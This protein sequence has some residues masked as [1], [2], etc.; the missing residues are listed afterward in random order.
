[1]LK[2][3]FFLFLFCC[4]FIANAAEKPGIIDNWDL[5]TLKHPISEK[6]NIITISFAKAGKIMFNCFKSIPCQSGSLVKLKLTVKGTGKL[7]MGCHGYN[8]KNMWITSVTGKALTLNPAKMETIEFNMS[9]PVSKK[10]VVKAIRPYIEFVGSK[11]LVFTNFNY[12]I[13]EPEQPKNEQATGGKFPPYF[14]RLNYK[15]GDFPVRVL[16]S[17]NCVSL[18]FVEKPFVENAM[19]ITKLKVFFMENKSSKIIKEQTFNFTNG[20]IKDSKIALPKNLKGEYKIVGEYLDKNHKVLCKGNGFT[21]VKFLDL[22]SGWYVVA[23]RKVNEHLKNIVKPYMVGQKVFFFG[24]Y[25]FQKFNVTLSAASLPGFQHPIAKNQQVKVLGRTYH[26]AKNGLPSQIDVMQNEPTVG[27]KWEKLLAKPI[28]LQLDGKTISSNQLDQVKNTSTTQVEVKN[29]LN[30]IFDISSTIEQDGVIKLNIK[31]K[32]NLKISAGN[33]RI[34]IPL[35]NSQATLYHDLTDLTYRRLNKKIKDVTKAGFGGHAGFVPTKKI[36]GNIV[37]QS[38]YC[39]RTHPGSFNAMVWL[40]NE[41]R[42]FCCFSDSDKD[43]LVDNNKSCFT[44]ERKDS[45]VILNIN[46]VNRKKALLPKEAS[47]T[48][49]LLATPAKQMSPTARGTIFPRWATLDKKFYKQLTNVKKIQMVGAGDPRFT[50]G[51]C[52]ILPQDSNRTKKMYESVKDD[53]NST[54]MEYYCSDYMS[55]AM[56]E[57]GM[58]FGEWSGQITGT[59]FRAP[60]NW[61]KPYKGFDFTH[62]S[63]IACRRI[64]PSYLQ[65]RL[66]CID[67][68]FKSSP[69]LSFYEDNIHLRDFFDPAMGYGYRAKDKSPRVEFDIW[70]LRNYYRKIAEIYRKHGVENQAG[71]HA[72]AAMIIPALTYC[73]YFIDGEQPGRY[74]TGPNKDYVD[75]WKDV[76]Y[77]RGHILGRQFGIR[78]IFLS[79]IV[80]KGKNANEDNRQTRAYLAVMLPHD[81]AIWDGAMKD[82]TAVKAWHKIVNDFNFY[83][84]N[85]RLYPYWATGKYKATEYKDKNLLVTIYRQKNRAIAIISNF[86]EKRKVEFKLNTKNLQLS[87]KKATDLEN[88]TCKDLNFDGTKV[89][90]EIP[91]HDYR[92]IL[93]N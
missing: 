7:N 74:A 67:Q 48:I 55:L 42:G 84:D 25:P 12:T 45:T 79:E 10:G 58:Y 40:G 5:R 44:I 41:D 83:N 80:Y 62:A 30:N 38:I 69:Q 56:P 13:L 37:W 19:D 15:I 47:W 11:E 35:K 8:N 60:S 75:V 88:P 3:L 1:M 82:R 90:L 72:S 65:Y 27:S 61:F 78:S 50:A 49:G 17:L 14:E 51:S 76:D 66:W 64:V 39:D 34:Q 89:S 46:L 93:F 33:L 32:K 4:F 86:G 31:L 71:A 59:K 63:W 54:F 53:K 29:T 22:N 81:I 26:F 6:N 20:A 77:L 91:R 43:F 16:P 28:T 18:D 87:P 9:I 21:F 73:P 23:G 68:K 70:S 57:L 2:K 92:V 36:S 24:N 52:A 85:P